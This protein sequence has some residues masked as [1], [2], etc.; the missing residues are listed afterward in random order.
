MTDQTG[1]SRS[2]AEGVVDAAFKTVGEA[3]ANDQSLLVK[4]GS[5]VQ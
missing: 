1:L 4:P 3:L 2:A 5:K